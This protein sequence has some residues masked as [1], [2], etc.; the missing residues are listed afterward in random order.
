MNKAFICDICKS[1][2]ANALYI[3]HLSFWEGGF[4]CVKCEDKVKQHIPAFAVLMIIEI[5]SDLVYD[6]N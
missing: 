5:E 3:T 4:T 1:K 6:K 2:P